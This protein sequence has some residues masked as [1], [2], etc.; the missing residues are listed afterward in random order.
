[1]T[2]VGPGTSEHAVTKGAS[3][4]RFPVPDLLGEAGH[5]RDAFVDALVDWRLEL[6][7]VGPGVRG[8]F[9]LEGASGGI[10]VRGR[11]ES[12]VAHTCHRCLTEWTD[13]ISLG[14]TEVLGLEGDP[15]GY[16]LDGEIVDLEPVI[17]DLILLSLPVV[18][19]CRPDCRGLCA[20][21]G[22]D[23]NT[24]SCPGHDEE[25]DSPF[26]SLRDLLEP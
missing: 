10:L 7:R 13:P 9:T 12:T 2:L 17:R 3:P 22:G 16:P 5:R 1:M 11:V 19:T 21:C 20:R 23:L 6:S 4:F 15:D 18:P 14:L 24:G 25:I 26:A 8:E